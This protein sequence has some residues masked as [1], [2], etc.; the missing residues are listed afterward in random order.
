MRRDVILF[1]GFI[2]IDVAACM[3]KGSGNQKAPMGRVKFRRNVEAKG[4]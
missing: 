2:V 1:M 4:S 3:E